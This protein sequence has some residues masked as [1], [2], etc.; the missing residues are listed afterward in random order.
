MRTYCIG[1]GKYLEP[2]PFKCA[3]DVYAGLIEPRT[4]AGEEFAI[5]A[6]DKHAVKQA[7]HE[8][9]TRNARQHFDVGKLICNVLTAR[10]KAY[11]Q[12]PGQR[13]RKA[14]RV[15]HTIERAVGRSCKSLKYRLP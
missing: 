13:P 8:L 2:D 15:D 1:L 14:P 12:A 11:P 4:Q 5:V 6:I 10:H 7:F 9:R 3:N